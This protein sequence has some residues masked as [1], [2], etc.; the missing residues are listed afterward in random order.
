MTEDNKKLV[1]L[2]RIQNDEYENFKLISILQDG[3]T[4]MELLKQI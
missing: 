1:N 3:E 4:I 2:K